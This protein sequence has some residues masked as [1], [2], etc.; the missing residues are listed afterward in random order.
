MVEQKVTISNVKGL[1]LSAA[2][3]LAKT[4]SA[5]ESDIRVSNGE[6]EVDAK[7]IMGLIGL[8]ASMGT[9]VVVK[10]DGADEDDAL[11]AV[12]ALFNA[13]FNEED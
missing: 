3:E 10:A 9:E 13:K 7:S 1:H 4:A 2:A 8:A 12:I 11:R 6:M 5:F